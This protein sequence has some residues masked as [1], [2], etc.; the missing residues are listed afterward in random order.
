MAD[1]IKL[2]LVTP[3]R[4]VISDEFDSVSASSV[5]G[6]FGVLPG[7]APLLTLLQAGVVVARRKDRPTPIA[8]QSGFAEV[9]PGRVIILTEKAALADEVDVKEVREKLSETEEKL[10]DCKESIDSLEFKTLKDRKDWLQAQ[11]DITEIRG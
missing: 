8:I 6:E 3:T 5:E 2:D 11:L 9:E 4:Q 7:H 1:N 10:K